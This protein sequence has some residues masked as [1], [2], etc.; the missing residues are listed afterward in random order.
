M[1]RQTSQFK[2]N[3]RINIREKSAV[4]CCLI[5]VIALVLL[6]AFALLPDAR[7]DQDNKKTL[8]LNS[9]ASVKKYSIMQNEF[10]A[11]YNNPTVEIDLG[12][13]WKDEEWLEKTI[14]KEKPDLIFC[15]GSKAY[16]Q[17]NK[18]ARKAPKIFSLGINWQRL[19]LNKNTIVVAG[20]VPAITQLTMY[21]YFFPDI[22]TIGILYSKS[23]NKQW[24]KNAVAEAKD[25][26]INIIGKDI[27]KNSDLSKELKGL[28]P[29]V[30]AIWLIPDPV[31][32]SGKKQADQI[33]KLCNDAGKP[34]FAYEKIFAAFGAAFIVS[35][36]IPT[37]ARQ[38]AKIALNIANGAEINEKTQDPAGSYIAINLNKI[39]EYGLTLNTRA[40]SS[41]NEFIEEK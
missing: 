29:K 12:S 22:D 2:R 17:S 41:V 24:F 15:I 38:S 30:D 1:T 34:V 26:G 37:M 10:K 11:K 27:D 39:E 3:T 18:L 35:A 16:I 19:P 20:E 25:I 14:R 6:L 23:N 40:L 7:A 4:G 5:S 32:I 36:D 31:I 8:I 21:R 13:K 9:N 33:F 28:L